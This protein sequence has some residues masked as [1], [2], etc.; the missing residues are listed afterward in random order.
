M[1]SRSHPRRAVLSQLRNVYFID[2]KKDVIQR[3]GEN[4]SA[5]EVE[6][7]LHE[8]PAV[9]EAAVVAVPD[10]DEA[11][12]AIIRVRAGQSVT[13]DELKDFCS[14]RMAKFKVPQ[15]YEFQTEEFP[16]TS[17]GKIRK[18]VIRAE[19]W[20]RSRKEKAKRGDRGAGNGPGEE[21]RARG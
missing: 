14:Q 11:V 17:I 16:K 21:D 8:H 13:E 1:R 2:R 12:L 18:N 19:Y 10:R 7:V 3:G 4:I 9:G 20:E 5:A 6:R 15:Y